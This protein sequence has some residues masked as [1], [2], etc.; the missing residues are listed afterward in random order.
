MTIT[1]NKSLYPLHKELADYHA[2][3]PT[4]PHIDAIGLLTEFDSVKSKL[5]AATRALEKIIKT[6]ESFHDATLLASIAE[7]ALLKLINESGEK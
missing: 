4:E 2:K 6:E 7:D 1:D 3:F 5:D